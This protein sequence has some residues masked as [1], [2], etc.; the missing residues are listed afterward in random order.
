MMG[1]PVHHPWMTEHERKRRVNIHLTKQR[2]KWLETTGKRYAG[3][4]AEIVAH[5]RQTIDRTERSHGVSLEVIPGASDRP[6]GPPHL[7]GKAG[8]VTVPP[9]KWWGVG[10]SPIIT[11]R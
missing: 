5:H 10:G 3:A 2:T 4:F 6:A 8:D 1:P 9:E 7:P 11:L